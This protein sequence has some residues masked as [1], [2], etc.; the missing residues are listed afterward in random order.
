[1]AKLIK[2]ASHS[3]AN[4]SV[5]E[6]RERPGRSLMVDIMSRCSYLMHFQ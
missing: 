1:M 4:D 3:V 6:D 5:K 2:Y